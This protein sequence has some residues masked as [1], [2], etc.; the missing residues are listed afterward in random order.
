MCWFE[1][2]VDMSYKY[3]LIHHIFVLFDLIRSDCPQVQVIHQ[4]IAQQPDELTLMEGDVISVLRKLPDGKCVCHLSSYGL[5][6]HA[7]INGF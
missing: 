3:L 7:H 2:F 5:L 1:F 4:Y 6:K